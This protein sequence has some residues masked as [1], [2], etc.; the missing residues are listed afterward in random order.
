M[1]NLLK[2]KRAHLH[3]T[4]FVG[5]RNLSTRLDAKPDL[6]IEYDRTH[7]ELHVT[8]QK[9]TMIVPNT[10]ISG[11]VS[12]P[13]ED[14][15]TKEDTVKLNKVLDGYEPVYLPQD[16]VAYVNA[17]RKMAGLPPLPI[18]TTAQVS[19]PQEHVFKGPGNGKTGKDK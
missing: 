1:T 14:E 5:G 3:N 8:Y 15:L 13:V 9:E 2:I 17:N 6:E 10:N 19:S 12:F 7:K 4:I 16:D 11:M 18:K